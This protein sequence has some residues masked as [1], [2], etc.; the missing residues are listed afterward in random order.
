M[1]GLNQTHPWANVFFLKYTGVAP[2]DVQLNTLCSSIGSLWATTF[3]TRLLASTSL[4]NV[5]AQ[6][7]TNAQSANGVDGTTRT[8]TG[9]AGTALPVSV[10]MCITW[11]VNSRWRGGHPR[12]YLSGLSGNDIQAGNQWTS[13]STTSM[14]TQ[15]TAFRTGLNGLTAAGNSWS[16]VCLRRHETK[17]DG[18]HSPIV[19]PRPL[20]IV[21]ELV[22]QR[23]DS[24]RRRLGPDVTT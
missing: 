14:R 4:T 22:D 11:H 2:T 17:S 12:T 3:G 13:A 16:F 5:I 19:P 20:P 6:D 24:Q 18:T 21:S 23:I 10:A 1:S 15:A 9:A 7:L 8:A